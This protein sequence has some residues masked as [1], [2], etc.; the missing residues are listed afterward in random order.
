MTDI[1]WGRHTADL[2]PETVL[3]L[4]GMRVNRLAAVGQW[5]PVA[6]SMGG[7]LAEVGRDRN[8]GFL[9]ARTWWSGRNILVQQY[10]R[11]TEDLL[12]YAHDSSRQHRPAWTAFFKTV[13][14][15]EGAAVG[16]WHETIR[17]APGSVETIYG[18]MPQFGLGLAV[19]LVPAMGKR[20]TAAKRLAPDG[21]TD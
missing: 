18:N 4:I 2:G 3:F 8:S 12:A 6:R 9:G 14:V 20:E 15:G 19:G 17:L 10:W 21:A 11:S 5:L 16:I 1:I 7:M 13:G